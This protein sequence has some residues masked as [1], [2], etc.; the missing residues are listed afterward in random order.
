MTNEEA[1]DALFRKSPVTCKGIDYRQIS[2]IIYRLNQAGN[3]MI[4]AE[5]LDK[6]TWSVTF[7]QL[8]DVTLTHDQ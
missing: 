6:N 5:L 2:A 7:A 4:T 3:L 8:K 1:K